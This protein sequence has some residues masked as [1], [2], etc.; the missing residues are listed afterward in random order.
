MPIATYYLQRNV[1]G[2]SPPPKAASVHPLGGSSR[3]RREKGGLSD[4]CHFPQVPYLQGLHP[5]PLHPHFVR[6][7]PLKGTLV[8]QPLRGKSF[9]HNSTH[10]NPGTMLKAKAHC[11]RQRA[12]T[13]WGEAP[14]KAGRRG[15]DL[16]H[17]LQVP[18]LQGLHPVPLHPRCARELPL[19]GTLD[20]LPLRGKSFL[21]N[22]THT[23]PGTML[24][25]KAHCQ[26]Q[27]ASTPWGEAP[28]EA[29]RRGAYISI[30]N[31]PL[32]LLY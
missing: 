17:F 22:S 16:Y 20:H 32:L 15:A 27:R 24:K 1:R 11:R 7:L 14:G 10:T 18:Y 31:S 5:V 29:G 6:E 13:P 12:S 9:L 23:K 19:K 25:A 3:Q 30:R 8:H 2:E 21:H 4:L 28:G 26:R